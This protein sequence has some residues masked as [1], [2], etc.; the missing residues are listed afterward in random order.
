MF[1]LE[2][3]SIDHQLG[4]EYLLCILETFSGFSY[5]NSVRNHA[6]DRFVIVEIRLFSIGVTFLRILSLRTRSIEVFPHP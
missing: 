2:R 5:V 4:I 6:I 3:F 1:L